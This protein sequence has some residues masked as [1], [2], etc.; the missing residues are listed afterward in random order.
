MSKFD[1]IIV[2]AGIAGLGVGGLLQDKGLKTII[3]EKG[4]VSGGR[5]KTFDFPGGWKVDSG[6]H[7]IELGEYSACAKLLAKLGKKIPWSRNIEGSMLY[8]DGKWKPMAEYLE[9]TAADEKQMIEF[10][11]WMRKLS[12]SDIDELDKI[13]L[14]KLLEDK[15]LSSR[16]A[17]FMKTIG[18]VQTTLTDANSISAGEFVS[19]YKGSL[20]ETSTGRANPFDEVRMPL[21]GIATMM[22]ALEDAYNEKGGTLLLS[23][24][25]KKV[26]IKP[27]GQAEVVMEKETLQAPTVVIA[28]PIWHM[29]K[30]LSMNEMKKHSPQWAARMLTLERETSSSM[31]FTIGTKAPLLKTPYYLSAWRL[32]GVDLPMQILLHTNFDDTIAPKDHTIAFIG[33]CCT[34]DEAEN[35][36]FREKTLSAF[37]ELVKKMFPNVEADLVWRQDA[38]IVGID[39]LARSPGMTGKLRPPVHLPEV[40]GLYF[41]GDCYTGRGVGMNAA[42]NSAMIC[43]DSILATIR[44]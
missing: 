28:V 6:T 39:G 22:K 7:A 37:W 36:K 38:F 21:G 23:T 42:S 17:E 19:I 14:T 31:G 24:A 11:N 34:P 30:I 33:A 32:P 41:A 43:A 40:P 5:C 3:I 18:M 26:N 29:L 25:V 27:G 16:L 15:K 35:K 10:E 20:K 9:M 44:K 4:K 13:S 8:D 2:G 1:V 12:E